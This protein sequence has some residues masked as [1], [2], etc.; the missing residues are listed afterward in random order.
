MDT[1]FTELGTHGP[2]G[3]MAAIGF[4]LFLMERRKNEQ[5]TDKLLEVSIAGIR[6]AEEHSKAYGQLEK[7]FDKAVDVLT[8]QRAMLMEARD[9]D[10]RR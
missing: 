10:S 3:I 7:V 8:S 9:E 5:L 1:L 6:A 4:I 2:L